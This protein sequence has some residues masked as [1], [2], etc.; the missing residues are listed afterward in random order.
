[1]KTNNNKIK[2]EIDLDQLVDLRLA[3][4]SLRFTLKRLNV[5]DKDNF[6]HIIYQT[7]QKNLENGLKALDSLIKNS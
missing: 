5:V 7:D 4:D 3:L 1:M 6:A 2:T